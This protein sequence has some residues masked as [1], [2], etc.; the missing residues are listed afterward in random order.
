MRSKNLEVIFLVDPIDEY[1]IQ[2]LTEFDEEAAIHHERK[3]KFGDEEDV[4]KKERAIY[5]KFQEFD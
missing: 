1:A 5:T 3:P 4:D 2:N